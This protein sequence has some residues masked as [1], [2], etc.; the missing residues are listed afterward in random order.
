M[1]DTEC[2]TVVITVSSNPLI[3]QGGAV[4]SKMNV[5]KPART[6][7]QGGRGGGSVSCFKQLPGGD[8]RLQINTAVAG[9]SFP[10]A[11]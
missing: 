6:D 7:T 2:I 3:P 5:L 9:A 4:E 11:S 8:V 1:L 10:S